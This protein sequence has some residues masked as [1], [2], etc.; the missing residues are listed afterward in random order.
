[1]ISTFMMTRMIA[2]DLRGLIYQ[3]HQHLWHRHLVS[4]LALVSHM[5]IFK[6]RHLVSFLDKTETLQT[7]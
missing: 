2:Q 6:C 4:D 1:M 3:W 5:V 7:W